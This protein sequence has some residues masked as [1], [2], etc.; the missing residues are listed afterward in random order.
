MSV[1][2]TLSH[3]EIAQF[4]SRF[5]VGDFIDA[6]GVS[7]G[8]ENTNYFV[9]CSAGSYVLTLV[10]RGPRA[11]L[12]FFI[13]LLDCLHAADMPV[14]YAIADRAGVALHTLKDKPALL[15]PKLSGE[16]V[17]HVNTAQCAALGDMLARLHQSACDLTRASDRGPAWTVNKALNLLD[18]SW[19]QHQSWLEP[20][21]LQLR[22]WLEFSGNKTPAKALPATIIHGDLF[23]DNALFQGDDISG[24]IDFYNAASGWTLFDIAVCVNDWCVDVNVDDVALNPERTR[25]LLDAYASKRPF[26]DEEQHCWPLMLQLAALRF[27]V[28]RQQYAL[29]HKGQAGILI[30]DPEYFHRVT[31][32][33][34][35]NPEMALSLL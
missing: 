27:W 13:E 35:L 5:D 3:T 17:E 22:D 7:G 33:H 9:E 18:E 34:V 11:D 29:E 25:A 26:S 32:M 30:K 16:H 6:Q 8:S 2:T 28:S 23:R 21:L 20:A 4:V 10:E 1:F 14:P 19:R 15:Q 12:P 31:K 24:I